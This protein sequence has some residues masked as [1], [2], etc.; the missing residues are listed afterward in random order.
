MNLKKK[1]QILLT[2]CFDLAIKVFFFIFAKRSSASKSELSIPFD[3]VQ[4]SNGNC[5][6]LGARIDYSSMRKPFIQVG[7]MDDFREPQAHRLTK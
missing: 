6:A 3:A 5:H 2:Y 4:I 1:K 7:T